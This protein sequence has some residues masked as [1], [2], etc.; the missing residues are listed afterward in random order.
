M[1][2]Q[3]CPTSFEKYSLEPNLRELFLERESSSTLEPL[4]LRN[5]GRPTARQDSDSLGS[6]S[7]V[8]PKL[9]RSRLGL[10]ISDSGS[11]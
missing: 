3:T 10:L 4:L 8:E 11:T 2:E 5:Y 1:N 9:L 7:T 6:S